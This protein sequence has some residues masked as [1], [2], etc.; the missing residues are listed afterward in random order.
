[1]FT[2]PCEEN[3]DSLICNGTVIWLL[4]LLAMLLSVYGRTL[5]KAKDRTQGKIWLKVLEE[6][7]LLENWLKAGQMRKNSTVRVPRLILA[8]VTILKWCG[9]IPEELDALLIRIAV[10][11]ISLFASINLQEIILVNFP[12]KPASITLAGY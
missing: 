6:D 7:I 2:T 12:G 4:K 5:L 10:W 1:M 9:K 11:E 8:P 3:A